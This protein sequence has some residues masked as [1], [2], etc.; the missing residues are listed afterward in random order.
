MVTR[1]MTT[2][3]SQ[4]IKSLP[5]CK[6][7]RQKLIFSWRFRTQK[8][9][10]NRAARGRSSQALISLSRFVKDVPVCAN[11]SATKSRGPR[12]R[13]F[14]TQ[15]SGSWFLNITDSPCSAAEFVTA[16]YVN[17]NPTHL[18]G[19]SIDALGGGNHTH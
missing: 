13:H 3:S 14:Y 11:V 5:S 16:H 1:E 6:P 4:V 8:A 2:N 18:S 9:P 19:S 12:R 10:R 17:L 15:R 7:F